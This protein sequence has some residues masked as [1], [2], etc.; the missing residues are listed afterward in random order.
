MKHAPVEQLQP[1]LGKEID[2]VIHA[3]P[4]QPRDASQHEEEEGDVGRHGGA[5]AARVD[6]IADVRAEPESAGRPRQARG[7]DRLHRQ[8]L[9]WC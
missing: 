2:G 3:N 9:H 6:G 8:R 1:Q 4:E 7:I 5:A